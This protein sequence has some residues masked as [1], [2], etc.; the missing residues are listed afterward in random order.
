MAKLAVVFCS[1]FMVVWLIITD[2]GR[3]TKKQRYTKQLSGTL[4]VWRA[5]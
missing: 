1:P 4:Q 2:D 5:R 3:A